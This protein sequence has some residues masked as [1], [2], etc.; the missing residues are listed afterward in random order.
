MDNTNA[1]VKAVDGTITEF[2]DK[3]VERKQ[4]LIDALDRVTAILDTIDEGRT[5]PHRG[6]TDYDVVNDIVPLVRQ[7]PKPLLQ[8]E[9][10]AALKRTVMDKLHYSEKEAQSNIYRSLW[11]HCKNGPTAS[12][13]RGLRAVEP[14]GSA[15]KVV[16]FKT[17]GSR[18]TYPDNLIWHVERVK[19]G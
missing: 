6:K 8:S 1:I 16:P 4:D 2:R 17:K 10:F 7:S 5:A 18:S 13:D 12:D 11:Y 14:K 15:F 19:A 3:L 9:I